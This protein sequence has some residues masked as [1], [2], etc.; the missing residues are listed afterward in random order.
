MDAFKSLPEMKPP[1]FPFLQNPK[2]QDPD[3]N[4][5]PSDFGFGI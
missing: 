4:N 2:K 1:S 3:N 5:P